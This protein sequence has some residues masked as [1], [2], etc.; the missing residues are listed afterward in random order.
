MMYYEF[1]A[2]SKEY[3]LR[4][5]TRNVVELEKRLGCNPI[6]IFGLDGEQIPTVSAMVAILHASLQTHHHGITLEKAYDIFDSYLEDGNAAVDFLK[7]I[8]EVY[9]VSGMIPKEVAAEGEEKN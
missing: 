8:M 9:K 5:N 1:N 2:G 4:L 6:M 3:K 7:I